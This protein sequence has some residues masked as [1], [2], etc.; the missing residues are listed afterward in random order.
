MYAVKA[1]RVYE[2]AEKEKQAFINRGYRIAELKNKKLV[3]EKVET[4]EDREIATLKIENKK[5][6]DELKKKGG[7]K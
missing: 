5:L 6:K 3:Y 4:K 1:N 7:G 2:I